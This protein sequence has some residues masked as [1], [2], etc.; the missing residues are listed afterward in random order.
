V[1]PEIEPQELAGRLATGVPTLLLD[2]REAWEV[3]LVAMPGSVH[4]PLG[5]LGSRLAEIP[6]AE[7]TLIVTVCHHGI[8]SLHA[9][10]VL[11]RAGWH[12][13]LSLAGGID[14]WARDVDPQMQRYR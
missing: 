12:D 4:V 9:A 7:D 6:D 11:L 5:E 1:R 3:D 10:A 14:R 8:R 13:V 2:V